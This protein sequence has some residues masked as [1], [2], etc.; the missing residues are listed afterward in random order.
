MSN[1]NAQSSGQNLLPYLVTALR[2]Y[3]LRF[4]GNELSKK[5]NKINRPSG[6]PDR[7]AVSKIQKRTKECT[8]VSSGRG[9]RWKFTGFS[10]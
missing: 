3:V 4:K 5:G 8:V 9:I 2:T 10:G 7:R 1:L 6:L